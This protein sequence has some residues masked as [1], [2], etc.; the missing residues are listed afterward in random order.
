[1]IWIKNFCKASQNGVSQI[2][3]YRNRVHR[4]IV[5]MLEPISERSQ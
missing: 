5:E 2:V 4:P 1:M 3:G